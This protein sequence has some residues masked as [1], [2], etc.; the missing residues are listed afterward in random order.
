MVSCVFLL[1]APR[2]QDRILSVVSGATNADVDA[3]TPRGPTARKR[4]P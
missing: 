2:T 3:Y 4:T 1:S